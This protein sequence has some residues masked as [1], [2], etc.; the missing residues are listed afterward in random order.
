MAARNDE[1]GRPVSS[2]TSSAR[3]VRRRFPGW[4]RA[5]AAG[6]AAASL[7][8]S[9]GRPTWAASASSRA[10]T[11]WSVGGNTKSSTTAWK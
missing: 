6:S 9:S 1:N 2:I 8:Y 10:R 4:T 3:T 5:A 11:A 7:A